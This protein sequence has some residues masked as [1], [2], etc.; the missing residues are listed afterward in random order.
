MFKT[1]LLGILALAL[2]G[3]LATGC[4]DDDDIEDIVD[5]RI[6]ELDLDDD[7]V[8]TR[9]EW[10]G[11]F[12]V[13][14]DDGDRVLVFNEF[15]FNGGG[16]DIADLNNDGFVTEDEWEDLLDAWDVDDDELLE[17]IEFAP[18]L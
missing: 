12:V 18:Y 15:R 17:E 13:W 4:D 9:A 8:V 3:L 10:A 5:E 6:D 2:T 11:A 16:F 1:R 7:L 14:D